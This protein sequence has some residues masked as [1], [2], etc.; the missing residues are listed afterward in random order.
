MIELL[1]HIALSLLP[2][3]LLQRGGAWCCLN[4]CTGL[5]IPPHLGCR[6]LSLQE[7]PQT[8]WKSWG[9]LK[10]F[11]Q[12]TRIPPCQDRIEGPDFTPHATGMQ[13]CCDGDWNWPNFLV[14]FFF[15][16]SNHLILVVLGIKGET[17]LILKWASWM[18]CFTSWR[19]CEEK[20]GK[21]P[22]AASHPSTE[23]CT[24]GI[25]GGTHCPVPSFGFDPHYRLPVFWL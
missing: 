17:K 14:F 6:L 21:K 22:I 16:K 5:H 2:P 19:I 3:Q 20:G 25:T 15:W 1:N 9:V 23:M 7:L 13:Q 8:N 10:T 12:L 11:H 4:C 24:L 18:N